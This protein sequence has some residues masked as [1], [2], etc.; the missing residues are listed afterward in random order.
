MSITQSFFALG[1][2]IGPVVG[3]VIVTVRPPLFL[4]FT[5][6]RVWLSADCVQHTSWRWVFYINLPISALAL[7][8]IFFFL[9][10]SYIRIGTLSERIRRVDFLGHSILIASIV[11]ILLPLTWGGTTYTWSSYRVLVPLFV[12]FVGLFVFGGHEVF[13]AKDMASI[14]LRLFGNSISTIGYIMTFFHG[15]AMVSTAFP[16]LHPS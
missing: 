7:I 1:T 2:F 11:S 13:I 15:I 5:P 12:G 9:R 16:K 3:G 10:L 6:S 4:R 14:P 8:F